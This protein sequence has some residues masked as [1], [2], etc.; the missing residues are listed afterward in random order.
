MIMTIKQQ[1]AEL[2]V[3]LGSA[4]ENERK[5]SHCLLP[6]PLVEFRGFAAWHSRPRARYLAK[7][8][9]TQAAKRRK[10]KSN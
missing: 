5:V 3:L 6:V 10:Y 8:P 1:S 7:S 9:A 2:A 4:R